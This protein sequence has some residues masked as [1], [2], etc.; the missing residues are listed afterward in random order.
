MNCYQQLTA[1]W[2]VECRFRLSVALRHAIT[3]VMFAQQSAAVL[4][5]RFEGRN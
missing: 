5:Q 1:L 3:V 2:Q 4:D